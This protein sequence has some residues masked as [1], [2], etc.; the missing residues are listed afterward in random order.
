[1][2]TLGLHPHS[3]T[4]QLNHV[5]EKI[6]SE[7]WE[8]LQ[9]QKQEDQSITVCDFPKSPQVLRALSPVLLS[10]QSQGSCEQRTSPRW[11][12]P[13]RW[14][15]HRHWCSESTQLFLISAVP[16]L[17]FLKIKGTPIS[18]KQAKRNL[19]YCSSATNQDLVGCQPHVG[20]KNNPLTP[21]MP[22]LSHCNYQLLSLEL[23][24]KPEVWHGSNHRNESKQAALRTQYDAHLLPSPDSSCKCLM[25]GRYTNCICNWQVF[26]LIWLLFISCLD[27]YRKD[28]TT[29]IRIKKELRF[30][31]WM[32]ALA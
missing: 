5:N 8:N 31:Y 17:G 29:V 2:C 26:L 15:P 19:R 10:D 4:S 30:I 3:S 11:Q 18:K 12:S 23:V 16:P 32:L 22:R 25:F 24:H 9:I 20:F 6:A 21:M 1:M 28:C 13:S 27:T 14:E 7:Y